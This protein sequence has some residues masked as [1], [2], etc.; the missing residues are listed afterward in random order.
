MI[1]LRVE[2]NFYF[3]QGLVVIDNGNFVLDWKFIKLCDSWDKCNI[4]I[5]M[6]LGNIGRLL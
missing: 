1:F 6:I 5:K 2:C 3:Y 4:C